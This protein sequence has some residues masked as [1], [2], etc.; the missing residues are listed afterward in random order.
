MWMRSSRRAGSATGSRWGHC[1]EC[2]YCQDTSANPGALTH[3]DLHIS[4]PQFPLEW[5]E[6][7]RFSANQS[8]FQESQHAPCSCPAQAWQ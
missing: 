4:H 5:E 8:S 6:Q 3:A 1:G 2:C 7:F